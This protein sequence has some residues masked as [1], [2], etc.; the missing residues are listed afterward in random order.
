MSALQRSVSK[1]IVTT[2]NVHKTDTQSIG[3][4]GLAKL[5]FSRKNNP[6]QGYLKTILIKDYIYPAQ[7]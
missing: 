1:Q 6:H 3:E 7:L 4:T 5:F 2:S